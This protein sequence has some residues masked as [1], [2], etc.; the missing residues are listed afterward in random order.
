MAGAVLKLP[1]IREEPDLVRGPLP[2]PPHPCFLAVFQAVKEAPTTENIELMKD[3]GFSLLYR[4][5]KNN[6]LIHYIARR[7]D[8]LALRLFL[9]YC[10]FSP[11]VINAQNSKGDTPLHIAYRSGNTD[12]VAMLE[13]ASAKKDLR[14]K[15]G[16]TYDSQRGLVKT[17]CHSFRRVYCSP[18]SLLFR[19][20]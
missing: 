20:E 19:P 7:G 1:T 16:R 17:D 14:N 3:R 5:E 10:A 4:D 8:A 15:K 9:T 6:M 18:T 2:F 13:K 12:I 11:Q